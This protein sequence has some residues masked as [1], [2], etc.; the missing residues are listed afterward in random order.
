MESNEMHRRILEAV[1]TRDC[2]AA[3][4]AVEKSIEV[5]EY[6]VFK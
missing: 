5:W 3:E 2:V 6:L 1:E 4:K